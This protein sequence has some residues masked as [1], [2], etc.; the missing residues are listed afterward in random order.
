MKFGSI[1]VLFAIIISIMFPLNFAVSPVTDKSKTVIL[2]LNVC[3][4]SG[5]SLFSGT[6]M[7]LIYECPCKPV[8]LE[9]SGFHRISNPAFSSSLISFQKERPPRV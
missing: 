1:L 3:D 5:H 7:P 9:F 8:P 6:D 4:K 2:T